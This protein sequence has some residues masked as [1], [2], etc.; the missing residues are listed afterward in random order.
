[1][2]LV[3]AQGRIPEFLK[4]LPRQLAELRSSQGRKSGAFLMFGFARFLVIIGNIEK[5]TNFLKQFVF[6]TGLGQ[7]IVGSTFRSFF[8]IMIHGTRREYDDSRFLPTR[9]SL[10]LSRRL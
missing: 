9:I 6:L 5:A 1:M 3:A 4:Q 2:S 8:T 7:K 10:N